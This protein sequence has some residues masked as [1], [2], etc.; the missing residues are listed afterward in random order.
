MTFWLPAQNRNQKSLENS[1]SNV[2]EQGSPLLSVQFVLEFSTHPLVTSV[3]SQAFNPS[4][5]AIRL[6]ASNSFLNSL[7]ILLQFF[8]ISP[9]CFE[10]TKLSI[11]ERRV[12]EK[13]GKRARR[14][15]TEHADDDRKLGYPAAV[16]RTTALASDLLYRPPHHQHPTSLFAALFFTAVREH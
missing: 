15:A 8:S 12:E 3:G 16:A 13:E 10:K 11:A 14:R 6:V 1:L 9:L 5:S 2:A 4:F 7:S